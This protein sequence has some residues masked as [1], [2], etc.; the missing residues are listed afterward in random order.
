MQA[1]VRCLFFTLV[2]VV[3]LVGLVRLDGV[4]EMVLCLTLVH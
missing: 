4:Y 2:G 1:G 3:N